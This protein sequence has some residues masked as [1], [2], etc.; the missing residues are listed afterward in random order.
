VV[1]TIIIIQI[2]SYL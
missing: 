1:N 2:Y